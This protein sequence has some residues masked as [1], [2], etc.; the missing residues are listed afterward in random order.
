MGKTTAKLK[1]SSK[2][3]AIGIERQKC[4][5]TTIE[6]RS[7]AKAK[8]YRATFIIKKKLSSKDVIR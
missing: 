4:K 7:W 1:N 2:A 3:E 5:D 8:E 6:G